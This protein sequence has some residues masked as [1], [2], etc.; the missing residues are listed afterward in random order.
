MGANQLVQVNIGF[1]NSGDR[2]A[3]EVRRVQMVNFIQSPYGEEEAFRLLRAELQSIG[4]EAVFGAP[5]ARMAFT[6]EGPRLVAGDC[7]PRVPDGPQV[8]REGRPLLVAGIIRYRPDDRSKATAEY[9]FY[10]MNPKVL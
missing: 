1:E 8:I 6:I 9:C 3:T 2:P 4:G 10:A 7:A 5:V